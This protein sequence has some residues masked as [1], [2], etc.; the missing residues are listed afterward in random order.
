M[1]R[2]LKT[3]TGS[4][5]CLAV[6]RARTVLVLIML[7]CLVSCVGG[8]TFAVAAPAWLSPVSVASEESHDVR[9]P[10]VAFDKQGDALAVWAVSDG[11]AYGVTSYVVQ[12]AIRPAGGAWHTAETI[13][14]PGESSDEPSLA[15]DAR[16]DAVI[17]WEAY[18]GAH[19]N[20]LATVRPAGGSWRPPVDL[21]S[22]EWPGTGRPKVAVDEAGDA[23][24]VWSRSGGLIQAAYMPAGGSWQSA[25]D[26]ADGEGYGDQPE[27]AFD[28]KGDVLALWSGYAGNKESREESSFKPAGG[29]WQVPAEATPAGVAQEPQ[30]AYGADGEAV[31]VWTN[32]SEGFLSHR[33]PE[34]AVMTTGGVWQKPVD[35]MGESDPLDQPKGASEPVVALDGQGDAVALWAWEYGDVIQATLRPAGGTW[36]EPVDISGPEERAQDPHV[37]FDAHGDAMAVW[38]VAKAEPEAVL[39]IQAAYR[40]AGGTWQAPVDLSDESHA[41]SPQIAFD[42]QGDAVAVWD[43]ADGVQSAGYAAAGPV[44]NGVS[45]PVSGVA[46]QPV[47]FSVSPLDVWSVLGET[48]WSFGD[49]SSASG[50][51]V[52]HTYTVPGTY[53][54]TIHSA[55]TLGNVTSSTG[56]ITIS[57]QATASTPESPTTGPVRSGVASSAGPSA[58]PA[59]E[60]ASESATRW[61]EHGKSRVGTVFRVSLNK[62]ATVT[63]SFLRD[64]GRRAPSC[65]CAAKAFADAA[66]PTVE[67]GS[68]SFAGHAGVNSVDFQGQLRHQ[69]KLTPG[70]YTLVIT[71]TNA[72][73]QRSGAKR[74]RFTILN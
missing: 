41:D 42:G 48:S 51:T 33:I 27:V 73:D 5:K 69:P 7:G 26:V 64:A 20:V 17:A 56:T 30:L 57:P 50:R 52:T 72:A 6:S 29:A 15:V 71:A 62:Q 37:A 74:L 45:I 4:P 43:H 28:G 40:P 38:S 58:A 3:V 13:S 67:D 70:S 8:A 2:E 25:N 16:G 34:A 65:R 19:F 1:S 11:T 18:N 59:I 35:L 46:G 12:V 21:S 23:I 22:N 9:E 55:D 68:I 24:A 53:E 66:S 39:R 60:T 32:W 36:Q 54:V 14:A 31:L 44:L 49:G 61:R 63:L 10:Q 47:S